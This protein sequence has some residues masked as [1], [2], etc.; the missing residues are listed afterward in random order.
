MQ[1]S[2][3]RASAIFGNREAGVDDQHTTMML[4]HRLL[5]GWGMIH[6]SHRIYNASLDFDVKRKRVTLFLAT[7]LSIFGV[8]LKTTRGVV[9]HGRGMVLLSLLL[10]AHSHYS[11]DRTDRTDHDLDHVDPTLPL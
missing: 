4:Q 2:Y 6:N 3:T 1:N 11:T 9:R 5:P 7:V 8:F 10:R